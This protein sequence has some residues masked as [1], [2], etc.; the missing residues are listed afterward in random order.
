M[1][2]AHEDKNARMQII[3]L[4][5]EVKGTNTKAK[6]RTKVKEEVEEKERMTRITKVKV[7]M[8]QAMNRAGKVILKEEKVVRQN[9]ITEE[10]ADI[11]LD[12]CHRINKNVIIRIKDTVGKGGKDK[13]KNQ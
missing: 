13:D 8:A 4:Q 10:M 7:V 6:E 5:E 11:V 3:H 1:A 2:L 12:H 9:R